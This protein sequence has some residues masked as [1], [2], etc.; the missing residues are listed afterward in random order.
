MYKLLNL[1]DFLFAIYCFWKPKILFPIVYIFLIKTIIFLILSSKNFLSEVNILNILD[2]LSVVALILNIQILIIIFA[3]YL[4]A[5]S[6]I[7]LF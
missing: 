7:T 1:I 5:K 3:S 2:F 6:L 4:L